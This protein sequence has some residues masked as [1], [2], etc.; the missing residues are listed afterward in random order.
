MKINDTAIDNV[1]AAAV[2]AGWSNYACPNAACSSTTWLVQRVPGFEEVW[3][4]TQHLDASPA[5]VAATYPACPRCGSE[6]AMALELAPDNQTSERV[7][8]HWMWR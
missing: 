7:L 4:V 1:A 5:L 6:L 3:R 8:M 2:N